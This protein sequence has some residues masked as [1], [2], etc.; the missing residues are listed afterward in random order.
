MMHSSQANSGYQQYIWLI[1]S[2]TVY[3]I[4]EWADLPTKLSG[5]RNQALTGYEPMDADV[6][7]FSQKLPEKRGNTSL[8]KG[9]SLGILTIQK[10]IRFGSLALT[11]LSKPGMQYSMSQITSNI[12]PYMLPTTM[13]SLTSGQWSYQSLPPPLVPQSITNRRTMMLFPYAL[14]PAHSQNL[15]R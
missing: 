2:R 4:T 13:I 9:Y 6:G 3:C 14:R 5:A 1:S 12:L 11:L 8:S 7:H 10:H 15:H